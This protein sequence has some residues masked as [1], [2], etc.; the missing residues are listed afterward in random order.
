MA[1]ENKRIL[2]LFKKMEKRLEDEKDNLSEAF[3]QIQRLFDEK[4][5]ITEKEQ[6]F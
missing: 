5:K 1:L 3:Q 6:N 4:E 2:K